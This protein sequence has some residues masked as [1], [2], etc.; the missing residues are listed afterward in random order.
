MC[1]YVKSVE[2][3]LVIDE[4]ARAFELVADSNLEFGAIDILEDEAGS[5]CDSHQ[6]KLLHACEFVLDLLDFQQ[7]VLPRVP[8]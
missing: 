7:V 4:V 2:T 3:V 5:A 1:E 6:V 8:L